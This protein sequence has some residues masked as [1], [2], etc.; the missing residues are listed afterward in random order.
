VI[1]RILRRT[2]SDNDLIFVRA[3]VSTEYIPSDPPTYRSYYPGGSDLRACFEQVLLDF[4]WTLPFADLGRDVDRVMSVVAERVPWSHPEANHQVQVL[5]SAFYRN[6]AAYL[7]GKIVNGSEQLPFLVPVLHDEDGRLELDTVLLDADQ[8][9]ALF[10]L[11]RAYFMA[12][13]DVPSAYVQFLRSMMP[14]RPRSEVYTMVGLGGQG[15]T[16]FYR[17]L[18]HHLHHSRDLFVEAPGIRGMVMHVF[19][20]ASY[21]YV[22]K[23]IRDVFDPAKT[24]THEIV[25]EKFAMVKDVDRVG[26]MADTHEFVDLALPRGRFSDELLGQLR[27]LA[28]SLLDEDE[29]EDEIVLRHCYVERRMVPL[30]L[31]LER[32]APE[33]V[34][35]AVRGY[36]DAIRELAV[37]NVFPGDL[38]WK[39]FGVTRL[40]RVV[41]YDY[42]ELE[43]LT[44]CTFRRI[45]EAQ[46]PDEELAAEP[47]YSV[48]RS[49][50]FP[51]EFE[52]FLLGDPRV[53]EAFLRHH[54]DL[55]EP[56]FWQACQRRIRAGEIVDFFPY[57]ES[58]R[59]R[60]GFAGVGTSRRS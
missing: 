15:K 2:Y 41:F 53:R 48:G 30:N 34:D 42:D 45:P 50:V 58:M 17:D 39:N 59:F 10:S 3:A 20:L 19:T 52:R 22:F 6:K 24:T 57:P 13:M 25:K 43:Y 38:L 8:I 47:W 4:G 35:A 37:A 21:P 44:D 27:E 49:D 55:L 56:E 40:G 16:L 12:D 54:A 60:N 33:E 31:Y 9:D 28:P 1:T 51:E 23:V 26:R 36:G 14:A 29:E 11:S 18:L 5:G 46:T 32:A 7:L